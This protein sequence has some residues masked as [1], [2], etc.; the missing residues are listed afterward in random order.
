MYA[1]AKQQTQNEQ[2]WNAFIYFL[3]FFAVDKI[4]SEQKIRI[5]LFKFGCLN[6]SRRNT[7]ICSHFQ[8]VA[9]VIQKMSPGLQWHVFLG[10]LSLVLFIYFIFYFCLSELQLSW[11]KVE[12]VSAQKHTSWLCLSGERERESDRKS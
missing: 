3:F 12:C 9:L 2:S 11:G 8:L 10:F 5:T 1:E 4:I 7:W 6:M